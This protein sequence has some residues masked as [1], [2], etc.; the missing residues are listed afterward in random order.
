ML[1]INTGDF[2]S[3]VSRLE[4]SQVHGQCFPLL[5]AIASLLNKETV[6]QYFTIKSFWNYPKQKFTSLHEI[7]CNLLRKTCKYYRQS[8]YQKGF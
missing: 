2:Y 5:T 1:F 4:V 8:N 6:S 3:P 7:R